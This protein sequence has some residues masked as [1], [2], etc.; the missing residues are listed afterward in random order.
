MR[1]DLV[2]ERVNDYKYFLKDSDMNEYILNMEFYDI[3]KIPSVGDKINMHKNMINNLDNYLYVFGSVDGLYG[4]KI[5]NLLDEDVIVL[6]I[7]NK[8]IYLKRFYG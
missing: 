5:D 6:L 1:V 2:I 3:D 8:K 4:K 7:D